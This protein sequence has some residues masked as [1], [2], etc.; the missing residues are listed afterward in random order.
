MGV[1]HKGRRKG[2]VGGRQKLREEERAEWEGGRA[3]ERKG[4]NRR[5]GTE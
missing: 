3:V 5:E 4:K 1:R 2:R